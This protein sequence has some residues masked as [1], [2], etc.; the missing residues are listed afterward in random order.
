VVPNCSIVEDNF[1]FGADIG[2]GCYPSKYPKYLNLIHSRLDS[3]PSRK[4]LAEWRD[5]NWDQH[6]LLPSKV[7][8][9][10]IQDPERSFQQFQEQLVVADEHNFVLL[11]GRFLA[12]LQKQTA[13][14]QVSEELSRKV[15][16]RFGLREDELCV[17]RAL[18]LTIKFLDEDFY[19]MF[20]VNLF[21]TGLNGGICIPMQN[22]TTYLLR[23]NVESEQP[24]DVKVADLLRDHL[25]NAGDTSPLCS[26]DQTSMVKKFS[27]FTH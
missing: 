1:A 7:V 8:V 2:G 21:P 16:E 5:K 20:R 14:A 24:K 12:A 15:C 25:K 27:F 17:G 3:K 6:L 13:S 18:E 23:L 26:Y 10:G 19:A 9:D 22:S 11:W 4:A